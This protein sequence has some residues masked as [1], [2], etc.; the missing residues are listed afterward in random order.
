MHKRD[1]KKL[2]GRSVS[3]YQAQKQSFWA[4]QKAWEQTPKASPLPNLVKMDQFG[5]FST[6]I[7]KFFAVF[8][9]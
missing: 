3:Y 8:T 6:K 2:V 7:A 5:D 9:I 4:A 1:S